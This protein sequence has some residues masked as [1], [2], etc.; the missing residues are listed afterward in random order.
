MSRG[1]QV[2]ESAK[3][4][5]KQA[6]AGALRRMPPGLRT[7][8]ITGVRFVR[9]HLP[10]SG[11]R[12]MLHEPYSSVRYS[13]DNAGSVME[14]LDSHGIPFIAMPRPLG[15]RLTLAVPEQFGGKVGVALR[16]LPSADGW[17]LEAR[18]A[19]TAS[20]YDPM[21]S[22][23]GY[24]KTGRLDFR[25]TRHLVGPSGRRLDGRSQVVDVQLWTRIGEN[26]PRA[27]GE[28]FIPGTLHRHPQSAWTPFAYVEPDQWDQQY[29]QRHETALTGLAGGLHLI[30]SVAEPIDVVYTWV[31]GSDPA[32]LER[33]ARI[34]G[35]FDSSSV[36]SSADAESRYISR[37]ELRYSLRSL[38]MYA[39]WVRNIYIVTDQQVP[40]WLN[41]ENPRIKVIDHSEIF[42]D[43]SVLPVYNSHAIESQLH[44]IKGLSDRYLYLN[45]DVFFG[46]EVSP[47][48]FFTGAGLS[49]Y[50]LSKAVL[51]IGAP[52]SRDLPVL[53]AAK[54][55]RD[56]VAHTF[57]RLLVQKFKHTPHAQVKEVVN[58]L[59][60]QFP[61]H[62]E[63]VAASR[64]RH[65][66]DLSI[67]SALHHY[68]GECTARS[69]E[70]TIRYDYFDLVSVDAQ[71]R[72]AK[73]PLRGDLDTFCI[74]DTSGSSEDVHRNDQLIQDILDEL[75]PL[76]S[77]FEIS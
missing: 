28:T 58:D 64:F 77:S 7:K 24:R 27:D 13:R 53:S 1:R 49:K 21:D 40:S 42:T 73:L 68:W 48:L 30:G 43:S 51:D 22:A 34:M 72:L 20:K 52:T 32:W 46:R 23:P 17:N 60:A 3:R 35:T 50:F 63:R 16:E 15:L 65:P 10:V 5:V 4:A 41:T 36:N 76:P 26:V 69:I 29:Q 75:F 74:N 2:K 31:D 62:F 39:D 47:S 71:S 67:T 6:G 61:E 59:E 44:H 14:L 37:D 9:Q 19:V 38:E 25:A 57:G 45:D 8:V 54:R 70:G 12:A 55:N 66:D 11:S 56:L 33:K 18:S